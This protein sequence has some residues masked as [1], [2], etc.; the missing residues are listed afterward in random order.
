MP[1]THTPLLS[2]AS[3]FGVRGRRRTEGHSRSPGRQDEPQEASRY[4]P[5]RQL[6]PRRQTVSKRPQVTPSP[7]SRLLLAVSTLLTQL[8]PAAKSETARAEQHADFPPRRSQR[9]LTVLR[10]RRHPHR[11]PSPPQARS[12]RKLPSLSE[13][14]SETASG[15]QTSAE[16]AAAT[17]LLGLAAA[18]V[19]PVQGGARLAV[20]RSLAGKPAGRGRAAAGHGDW[21]GRLAGPA[22][23]PPRGPRGSALYPA[24]TTALS[25]RSQRRTPRTSPQRL[26]VAITLQVLG[27]ALPSEELSASWSPASERNVGLSSQ[28][29]Q[30]PHMVSPSEDP[31]QLANSFP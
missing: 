2:A 17:P 22:P 24:C 15:E 1:H 9:T 14:K 25:A 16:A 5:E 29:K 23:A 18:S 12:E 4:R 20:Q 6:L 19:R 31:R 13:D 7:S 27:K 30:S 8:K 21:P 10:P 11:G 3:N 28:L 26:A